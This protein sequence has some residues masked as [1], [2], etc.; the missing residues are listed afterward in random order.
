MSEILHISFNLYPGS[1]PES[2]IHN[3][4]NIADNVWKEKLVLLNGDIKDGRYIGTMKI[5]AH[6][7]F[8]KRDRSE[9]I[10][11]LK[12]LAKYNPE[13]DPNVIYD[14]EK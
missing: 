8:A 6:R 1:D 4:G 12:Q 2:Q 13:L 11:R 9:L 7:P 5:I 3:L 14:K 10:K